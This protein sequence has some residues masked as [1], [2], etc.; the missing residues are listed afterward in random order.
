MLPVLVVLGA[1]AS[2][3]ASPATGADF[4]VAVI[5]H[6]SRTI[7]ITAEQV[8]RIYRKQQRFWS[9]G[10][11]ILPI[12]HPE[13][14]PIRKAF[15]DMVFGSVADHMADYWN[16]QYF[17]GVFPP[18]T[19]PSDASVRRFVAGDPASIGYVDARHVDS[20]VRVVL[21]LTLPDRANSGRSSPR[22]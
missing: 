9:D 12:N 4:T 6:P 22:D 7:A 2:S 18:P 10:K 13:G 16:E 11:Q 5:V 19:L 3:L 14:E 8:A 15:S 17:H 1:F 20:T 21:R